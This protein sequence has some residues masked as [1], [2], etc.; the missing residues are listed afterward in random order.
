MTGIGLIGAFPDPV[1][2]VDAATEDVA[3]VILGMVHSISPTSGGISAQTF[4]ND[5]Y[6][7]SGEGYP[8][9]HRNGSVEKCIHEAIW[10]LVN[11]D[12]LIPDT[13]RGAGTFVLTKLGWKLSLDVNLESFLRG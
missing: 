3:K 9:E 1:D 11:R 2:L 10:W 4:I 7:S 12:V 8:V 13:D 5:V 6:P